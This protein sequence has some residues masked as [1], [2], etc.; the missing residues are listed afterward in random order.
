MKKI[1]DDLWQTSLE[2]P[3][4]GLNTHAYFL[5]LEEA[6][7]LFYN[8]SNIDDI[9]EIR[10]M[11][12]IHTH[13]ISH[14]HESGKS[15]SKIKE[16]FQ[17]KLCASE[18]EAPFLA[19]EVEIVVSSRQM[20]NSVIEIIPTPGHTAGGLC[21]LFSPLRGRKYLFTGDTFYRS[22]DHWKTL[23]F[24]SDGGSTGDLVKSLKTL[25]SIDPDVVISSAFVGESA[26]ME[27]KTNQWH[28]EIDSNIEQLSGSTRNRVGQ[29]RHSEVAEAET[30]R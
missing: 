2:H 28:D 25:R 12:G 15:L 11:G 23:V 4:P 17:S 10:K 19:T 18:I 22:N 30:R 29:I 16:A 1:F 3:F 5:K 26:F 13:Y 21:F 6:N 14:R 24:S 27:M 20:H 9:D 8:T 7:V